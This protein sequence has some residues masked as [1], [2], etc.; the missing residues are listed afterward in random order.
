VKVIGLDLATKTGWAVGDLGLVPALGTYTL[1]STGE[2][3]G[4]F[5]H[6]FDEWFAA[7]ILRERPDAA[8][9][10]APILSQNTKTA[11]KLMCLAG[12]TERICVKNRVP[13][14]DVN[15]SSAKLFFAG[16]GHADK[17]MMVEAGHTHGFI[18]GDCGKCRGTG[19]N[20]KGN[21]CAECEGTGRDHNQADAG[22]I[23]SFGCASISPGII[24][25]AA[26]V[27]GPPRKSKKVRGARKGGRVR[28]SDAHSRLMDEFGLD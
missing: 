7:F 17:P 28:V 8:F 15:I 23:W 2:D 20:R 12:E 26:L 5:L 11:R 16:H 25:P 21:L 22:A 10:E 6:T 4:L 19:R 9:F 14:S 1:P 3:I 13:V 18:I 27:P 24:K